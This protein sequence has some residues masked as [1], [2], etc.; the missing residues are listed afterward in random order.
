[1]VLQGALGQL[2][3]LMHVPLR[4]MVQPGG[5]RTIIASRRNLHR[6]LLAVEKIFHEVGYE[7]GHVVKPIEEA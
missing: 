1:V 6:L 4:A 2:S 5:Q 7:V 3:D